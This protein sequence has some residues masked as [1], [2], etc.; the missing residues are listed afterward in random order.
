MDGKIGMMMMMMGGRGGWVGL[1]I[2]A[3]FCGGIVVVGCGIFSC[4]V[5]T[6]FH[7]WECGL[8]RGLLVG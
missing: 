7:P 2:A 1:G 8:I 5:L 4:A 6:L 3:T